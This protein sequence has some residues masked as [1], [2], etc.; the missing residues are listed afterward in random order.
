MPYTYMLF[1]VGCTDLLCIRDVDAVWIFENEI[2]RWRGSE[3]LEHLKHNVPSTSF[4]KIELL[5]L[6]EGTVELALL[7]SKALLDFFS[8]SFKV[9]EKELTA[10]SGWTCEMM[11]PSVPF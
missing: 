4:G 8:E 9:Q 3:F 2:T 6:K 1:P 7:R 10:S 11:D 5:S